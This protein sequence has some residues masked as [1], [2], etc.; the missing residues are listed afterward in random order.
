MFPPKLQSKCNEMG[1]DETFAISGAFL[2]AAAND[3]D[4]GGAGWR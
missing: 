2:C 3:E 4:E 1:S